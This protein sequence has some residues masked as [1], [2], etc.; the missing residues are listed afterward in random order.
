MP[1][2]VLGTNE[3]VINSP[4][5]RFCMEKFGEALY[6]HAG[7]LNTVDDAIKSVDYLNSVGFFNNQQ[8]SRKV[9]NV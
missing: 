2:K 6:K 7:L 3:G 8:E 9:S 5:M 1:L 4:Y